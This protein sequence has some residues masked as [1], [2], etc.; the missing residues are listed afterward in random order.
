[1]RLGFGREALGRVSGLRVEVRLDSW[2][3][4]DILF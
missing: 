2:I 1:M 3:S 4:L